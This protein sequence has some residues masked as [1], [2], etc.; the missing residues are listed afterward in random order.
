M[1]TPYSQQTL[2]AELSG[3]RFRSRR[4]GQAIVEFALVVPIFLILVFGILEY[5]FYVK[6][7]ITIAN[8]AREGARYATVG[9]TTTDIQGRV[10]QEAKPL[11]VA[12][13]S[14]SC[15][16]STDNGATYQTLADANSKN[17]APVGSLIR[18]TV[19]YRHKPLTGV[20]NFLFN[21]D[22]ISRVS[23]RRESA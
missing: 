6:N 23:M 16:F 14:V 19:T 3:R 15:E 22:L 17:T 2:C 10:I 4:R 12:S 5:A 8:A 1:Q 7:A 18:I 13:N 21:R 9:K 20:I 11:T